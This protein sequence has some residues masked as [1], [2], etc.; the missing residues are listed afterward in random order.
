MK[1]SALIPTYNRRTQVLRAIDSVFAQT[2]PVD[3]IIVVDDGSTDGSAE[4]IRSQYGSRVKLL[5][6]KNA[7]VSAARNLGIGEARGEWIAFLDSDD[8]W[9]PTKIERQFEALAALGEGFGLC[10]T[11]CVFDGNPDMKLSAFQ[12]VGLVNVPQFGPLEDP[13]KFVLADRMPFW[14]QS[15]LVRRELLEGADGF[16]HALVLREDVDVLFRLS[17]RT[18]F[19]FTSEPLV[20]ID[21]NPSRSVGLCNLYSQA[22]DRVFD[23]LRTLYSNWLTLPVVAGSEYERPV[24][25]L[26]RENYFSSAESK[27][28]RR[29]LGP[30][31]REIRRMRTMG[32]GYAS[33]V[34]T[35]ARRK[36]AKLRRVSR[37][38]QDTEGRKSID[39]GPGL[40]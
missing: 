10:F 11:D 12:L 3:E 29:R 37:G 7:G 15:L 5:Q 9:M 16:D 23:S 2:M 4:A 22:D 18:K 36:I 1:V 25:E 31:L 38:S 27:I 32:D 33:L 13:V 26:L 20:R 6:Q 40:A 17:F 39:A 24:R 8:V 28:R 30:A 19:C 14:T 21:R 35:L 34:F